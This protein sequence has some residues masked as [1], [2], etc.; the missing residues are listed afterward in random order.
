M[1]GKD[2]K[3]AARFIGCGP[4]ERSDD[5]NMQLSLQT[6]NIRHK[7]YIRNPTTHS[8]P[9]GILEARSLERLELS[10]QGL[11]LCSYLTARSIGNK[12]MLQ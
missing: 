12:L 5:K 11:Y 6:G 7:Q 8:N 9:S 3:D 2:G 10:I 4:S 1:S